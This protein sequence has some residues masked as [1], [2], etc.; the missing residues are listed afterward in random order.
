ME[1]TKFQKTFPSGDSTRLS[2]NNIFNFRNFNK[3]LFIIIII[4]GVFYIAGANDLATKGFVLSDMKHQRNRITDENKKLELQVM[5]LSSYGAISEK[6]ADL[7]MVAVG[8]VDY[9]NL[10]NGIVAKK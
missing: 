6:I 8:E 9:L 7:K 4:L 1:K 10:N 2:K 5:A 3:L